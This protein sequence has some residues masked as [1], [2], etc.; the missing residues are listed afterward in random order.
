MSEDTCIALI[1][2][3]N[4]GKTTLFNA[5]TGLRHR[6]GNFPGVTVEW[7]SG[8]WKIGDHRIE[9]LDLPGTYS[10]VPDSPDEAVVVDVLRGK[11]EGAPKP[12][13][14]LAIVDASNP[15]RNLYLVSQ[16]LELGLPVVIALNMVDVAE[17]AGLTIDAKELSRRIGVP[18]VPICANANAGLADLAGAMGRALKAGTPAPSLGIPLEQDA[19]DPVSIAARYGWVR[20]TLSGAV[21][22]SETTGPSLSDKLDKI[23]THRVWGTLVF[24]S[25]MALVFQSIYS[26]AN[27]IMDTVDGGIGF[28]ADQV[29]AAL[30]DGS[31]K[32]LLVDGV[33]AGVGSVL[34][35][36]PQIAILFFFIAVLE[37]CGYMARAAFLMDRLFAKL[38]L[39]GRSFIPLFSSF[40][41]AVPGVMACRTI[42]D[43]KERLVAMLVAP[44]MS[45]SAR[46]PVYAIMIGTFIPAKAVAGVFNLQGLTLLGMYFLGFSV[47]VPIA[48]V[49]RKTLVKGDSPPFMIELPSYKIP[50]WHVVL[51]RVREKSWAFLVRAGT[52][53]FGVTVVIWALAYYPHS[54][55]TLAGYEAQRVEAQS[56]VTDAAALDERLSE[57]GQAQA[58]QM[59]RE[60][61][62][63]IAGR[64][65]EP[66]FAPL[67][68]DWRI[69]MAALASFPAREVIIATLGTI[70]NLGADEDE[71]SAPLREQLQKAT[72]PDGT[73]LFD[74]AVAL[75]VM[76][77][78][79]LCAQCG[80][81]LAVIG[82]ESGSWKWAGF[83]FVYMTTLAYLAATATYQIMSRLI[84]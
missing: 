50:E 26:W 7:E 46:L 29:S 36:L 68:W 25:V 54:E 53:I 2:N 44:L 80:A 40:A 32:S 41:C 23:L 1:G 48:L 55:E 64:A 82:K 47:A 66:V 38:G 74:V 75:S 77:F 34:I 20:E 37:G 9:L 79:A 52:V 12:L 13:A 35:F 17:R 14:I 4:V 76:V 24:I 3:P 6:T 18:V 30:P 57:I 21:T 61:Y 60:S 78:F 81:T 59:L 71:A 45:C 62:L 31:L 63:G 56:A 33:I 8:S 16:L 42:P 83:T 67:G 39:S 84:A 65:V 11:E 27:P 19:P 5:L 28:V 49:V 73:P 10:L 72:W 51:H 43:R 69:S 15:E 58:G 22:R 70:F